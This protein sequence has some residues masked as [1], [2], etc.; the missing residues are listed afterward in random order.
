MVI[1]P[2]NIYFLKSL[3]VIKLE[4]MMEVLEQKLAT[5]GVTGRVAMSSATTEAF[6]VPLDEVWCVEKIFLI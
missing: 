1:P 6:I 2:I 4:N 5:M 3:Y